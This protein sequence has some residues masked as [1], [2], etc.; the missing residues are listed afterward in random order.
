MGWRCVAAFCPCHPQVI[1]CSGL[2]AA[3]RLLRRRGVRAAALGAV[4]VGSDS[5]L[6]RSKGVKT[7]LMALVEA[8]GCASLVARLPP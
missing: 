2:S 5:L 6:D 4:V 3:R 1:A 8:G 7:E